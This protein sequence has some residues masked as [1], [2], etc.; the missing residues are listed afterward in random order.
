MWSLVL[1]GFPKRFY[2]EGKMISTSARKKLAGG[3][4]ASAMAWACS[5]SSVAPTVPVPHEPIAAPA[6]PGSPGTTGAGG[7]DGRGGNTMRIVT[8]GDS[9]AD[10]GFTTNAASVVASSYI[11]PLQN[12]AVAPGNPHHSLQ[13][14]AKIEAQW[15]VKYGT[16]I[17]VVN[18]AS[19][20]SNSGTQRSSNGS[21]GALGVVNGIT[22]FDAE[23]LGV[24]SPTWNAGEPTNPSYYRAGPVVRQLA[25]VPVGTDVVFVSIGT[26]DPHAI[27]TP[28]T[29]SQT[30]ANL[31]IMIDKWTAAGRSASKFILTTL[32]PDEVGMN[33]PA[34]NAAI[35]K[36]A[37]AKGVQ[38]IDLSAHV[39]SD[40]GV[41]WTITDHYGVHYG[42]TVR[43]WLAEQVVI[44]AARS[45]GI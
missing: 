6:A 18:H 36:L 43:D 9:N 25:Y 11:S 45:A 27:P 20:G 31:G 32:P 35:R 37:A 14:A 16:P 2:P 34:M 38:L 26:N 12:I 15:L 24:G 28:L 3:L 33:V 21:T 42:P 44:A 30:A 7:T 29:P 39:S 1:H 13:L 22:R 8:F 4:V 41:T 17:R 40:D 5:G 19:G 10:L 23:V